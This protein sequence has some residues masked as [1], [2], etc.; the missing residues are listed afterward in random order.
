LIVRPAFVPPP[1][2][3][4]TF[5]STLFVVTFCSRMSPSQLPGS[6][7]APQNVMGFCGV[8]EAFNV[9]APLFQPMSIVR[10]ASTTMF[11]PGA[12]VRIAPP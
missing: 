9:A 3:T 10:P 5:A 8:P 6:A 11:V 7:A 4:S 2:D 12:M 1:S